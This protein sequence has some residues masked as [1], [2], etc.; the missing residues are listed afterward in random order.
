MP[1]EG[2]GLEASKVDEGILTQPTLSQGPD[3]NEVDKTDSPIDGPGDHIVLEM[4]GAVVE[5]GVTRNKG[6]LEPGKS[7]P[8]VSWILKVTLTVDFSQE[9]ISPCQHMILKART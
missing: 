5:L 3:G 8:S 2:A 7:A 1:L 6:S 4:D 9:V